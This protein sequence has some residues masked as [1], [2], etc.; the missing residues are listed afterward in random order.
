MMSSSL[1][2]MPRGGGTAGNNGGLNVV[3]GVVASGSHGLVVS[4]T[5]SGNAPALDRSFRSST[6]AA[7]M[8]VVETATLADADIAHMGTKLVTENGVLIQ[9]NSKQGVGGSVAIINLRAQS[10]GAQ[11]RRLPPC[12]SWLKEWF[13]INP[14]AEILEK[15]SAMDGR[16]SAMQTDVSEVKKELSAMDGRLSAIEDN[17]SAVKKDLSRLERSSRGKILEVVSRSEIRQI[18]GVGA[19]KLRLVQ[20]IIDVRGLLPARDERPILNEEDPILNNI[21]LLESYEDELYV[22]DSY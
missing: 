6:V 10:L 16:L 7:A 3:D 12:K 8:G 21:I 20:S 13:G 14:N 17:V 4:T 2:S 22:R 1:R 18:V 9:F 19:S 15:F 11:V 5:T